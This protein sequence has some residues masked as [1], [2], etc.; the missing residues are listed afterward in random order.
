ML[1]DAY[2]HWSPPSYLKELLKVK[3]ETAM[4]EAKHVTALSSK[5]HGFMDLGERLRDM[6]RYG[7]DA[8][9]TMVHSIIEPNTFP[10]PAEE[11]LRLVRLINDDV[12]NLS[13]KSEGRIHGIGTIPL[14]SL[15]SGGLEE[16]ERAV[17]D[18]GLK[19]FMVPTNS[20][21]V[22]ID[23]FESA[24]AMA[25]KLDVPLY[26]HP[27]DT[28]KGSG[29]DYETDYDL[30]HVIGWPYETGLVWMRLILSGIMEKYQRLNIITHHLGGIIPYLMGRIQESYDSKASKVLNPRGEEYERVYN[31][32]DYM[33]R[34]YYDTALGGNQPAVK[35]G[36]E[37]VGEDRVLFSTDYPWGPDS[38]RK[39]MA[40][41]PDMVS[42]LGLSEDSTQEIFSGRIIR[43]LK[44]DH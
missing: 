28:P 27:V 30:M 10:L 13:E 18:L 23:R 35:C 42:S 17:K 22:P 41:Y 43:L 4:R 33:K 16:M 34:F 44:L 11:N 29:R 2:T 37:V 26:I 24:L 14:M 3:D 9:V 1:I 5:K 15:N 8:Q 21:G 36:T 19:G 39:R 6:D 31:P 40:T 12:N 32:L 20:C 25:E 7:F 38:G